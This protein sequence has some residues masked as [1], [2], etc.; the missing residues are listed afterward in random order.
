MPPKLIVYIDS[1]ALIKIFVEED[2]SLKIKQYMKETV[3]VG[4]VCFMTAAITKAEIMAGLS[5]I[6][7]GRH[8]TQREFEEAVANFRD[9]WLVFSIADVTTALIDHAGEIGLTYKIKGCDAFQLASALEC[10]ADLLI[11]TD[12]D[13][14]A[15]AIAQGVNVWNPMLEAQPKI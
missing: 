7:R 12:N 2:G 15:A 10:E 4:N 3:A 5:A 8:I 1:S 14:N 6:R 11:S 9:L 13:L